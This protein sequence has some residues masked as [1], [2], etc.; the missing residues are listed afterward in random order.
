MRWWFFSKG[1]E[2]HVIL[3]L[4]FIYNVYTSP[5]NQIV[6]GPIK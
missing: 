3:K 6:R 5:T 4:F 1:E 2:D